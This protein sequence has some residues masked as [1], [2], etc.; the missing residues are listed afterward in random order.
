MTIKKLVES[1]IQSHLSEADSNI[2]RMKRDPWVSDTPIPKEFYKNGK[3]VKNKAY[4]A[5]EDSQKKNPPKAV[6]EDLELIGESV[7]S[8]F[9]RALYVLI[10]TKVGVNKLSV[11]DNKISGEIDTKTL[12]ALSDIY[13][14]MT[15]T[16]TIE[17]APDGSDNAILFNLEYKWEYFDGG[18]NGYTDRKAA[19]GI[20]K[21]KITSKAE[22]DKILKMA[23]LNGWK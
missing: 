5:W 23:N 20:F 10:G 21:N 13:K 19:V 4:W 9:E 6:K 8:Q 16:A 17:K 14:K 12:G 15:F 22:V 18:R 2:K 11:I 7:S 1:L 3:L